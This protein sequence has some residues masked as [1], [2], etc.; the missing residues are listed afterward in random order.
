MDVQTK[1]LAE[2]ITLYML[3]DEKFKNCIQGV[4]FSMPLRRETATGLALLPK[5]LT[6]SNARFTDRSALHMQAE[7]LYGTRLQAAAGKLGEMQTVSFIADS[8]A[9]RYVSEP[10]FSEVHALLKTVICEPR[11][12]DAFEEEAFRREK[13]ALR[14]D[15][16]SVVNDKRRFALVRCI[17]EMCSE[18]PFGIRA[19]GTEADLDRIT[20]ASAF[21]LYKEMLRTARVDIFVSGAFD[22]LQA[23]RSAEALASVLGPRK[24]PEIKCTRRIPSEVRY[25]QDREAVQQGKLVI[26]YRA[27]VDTETEYAA[28]QVF[29]AIFGGG[30]SSK[31]FNNVREKMSLCYYASSQTDRP[32]GLVLVQSGILFDKYQVALDAICAQHEEIKNGNISDAEFSGAVQGIVNS[33]RS[34]KDSPAALQ[35]YY[36]RQLS[37]GGEMNI[38]K[39]IENI[40]AVQPE[41]IPS[42]ARQIHMDTVYFLNGAGGEAK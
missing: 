21:A 27:D 3:P 13:E 8:I 6:A 28:L 32:K 23:E 26:G 16:K 2:G 9:D 15:I 20:P 30:T 40:L 14:E 17:E 37:G 18:E 24:A 25:V 11:A 12:K 1:T 42:I 31:L 36:V 33:L 10:L 34:C 5:L 41:Q 35:A 39:D 19:D 7:T 29:N 22:A 4:Y 38:E